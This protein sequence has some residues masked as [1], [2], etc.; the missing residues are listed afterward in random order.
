MPRPICLS[1]SAPLCTA[2]ARPPV[3][4]VPFTN[5]EVSLSVPIANCSKLLARKPPTSS[6]LRD[7]TKLPEPDSMFV[8]APVIVSS[9]FVPNPTIAASFLTDL[10]IFFCASSSSFFCFSF[11]IVVF[12]SVFKISLTVSSSFSF[13][14]A[15]SRSALAL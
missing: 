1:P 11:S 10:S 3:A 13:S 12:I 2:P 6:S 15:I 8:K 14:V 4:P 7:F 5:P 9:N